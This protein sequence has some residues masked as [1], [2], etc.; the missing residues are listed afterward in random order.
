M[1]STKNEQEKTSETWGIKRHAVSTNLLELD[2]AVDGDLQALFLEVACNDEHIVTL[3]K[4]GNY[5]S[6]GNCVL[7]RLAC[8][9]NN[10]IV[11]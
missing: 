5:V 10:K 4:E 7:E 1:K 3:A 2:W 6:I 11:G 9:Y 8:R